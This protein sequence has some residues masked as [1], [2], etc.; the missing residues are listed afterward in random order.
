MYIVVTGTRPE[1]IKTAPV[2]RRIVGEGLEL[3]FVHTGQHYDYLLSQQMI[4]DLNLPTPDKS[5]ILLTRTPAGQ[6]SEIMSKLEKTFKR[7]RKGVLIVQGDTNSVVS[8]A[9][10][11]VKVRMPIAHIESGLRSFDWRMPEEHNRRMVDHISDI[12]FAPTS[13]SEQNLIFE[14]VH[15]RIFVTGNTIIDAIREHLPLAL[16]TSTVMDSIRFDEYALG[17][18]HRAENV[19]D[20]K[21]LGSIVKGL[22]QSKIPIVLPLHPR[23]KK[24]LISMGYFEKIKSTKLIQLLPPLGYLDFLVLMKSCKFLVTDSGG[25]Q[26]EATAPEISKRVLVLRK[27]TERLEAIEGGLAEL[28]YPKFNKVGQGLIKEW[29]SSRNIFPKRSPYGTGYASKKIITALRKHF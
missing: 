14:H 29:N 3:C 2:I 18:F 7:Y 17:T 26:E 15:G 9:L 5:F 10:T 28:L 6:I 22:I 12:L 13:L 8:A 16:C 23:T 27:S 25:L 11:A 20:P 24:R 21:V 19:D 1:I 4:H